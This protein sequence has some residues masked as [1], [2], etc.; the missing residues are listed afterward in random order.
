MIKASTLDN[1]VWSRVSWILTD[2]SVLTR[3]IERRRNTGDMVIDE[4]TLDGL[5]AEVDR[6]REHDRR[7]HPRQPSGD[8]LFSRLETLTTERQALVNRQEELRIQRQAIEGQ[9]RAIE[10]W[11]DALN[12]AEAN[13]HARFMPEN[14]RNWKRSAWW[15][16]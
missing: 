2:A 10:D 14:E 4:T 1:A 5:L 8:P 9:N 12:D 3:E 7:H 15:S 6:H 11:I 13:V 16:R